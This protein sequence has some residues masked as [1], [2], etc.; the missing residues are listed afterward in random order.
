MLAI[1]IQLPNVEI[2]PGLMPEADYAGNHGGYRSPRLETH[3][4]VE[5]VRPRPAGRVAMK[6][7]GTEHRKS[8]ASLNPASEQLAR[9]PMPRRHRPS[10]YFTRRA[11]LLRQVP[12]ILF[13]LVAFQV[14]PTDWILEHLP[15]PT[16]TLVLAFFGLFVLVD[17]WITVWNVAFRPIDRRP[18]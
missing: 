6:V 8:G 17:T 18:T 4:P 9:Q 15:K 3:R 13:L 10:A 14:L 11:F 2:E 12:W 1:S 16:Q 7:E 5:V